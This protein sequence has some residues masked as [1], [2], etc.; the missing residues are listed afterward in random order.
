VVEYWFPY[1]GHPDG[2]SELAWFRVVDGTGYRAPGNPDGE[3]DEACFVI[4]EDFAFPTFSMPG[5]A[6]M[7]QIVGSFVYTPQGTAWFRIVRAI[8]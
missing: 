7:F 3:S 6:P 1:I 5:D 8:H 2:E 4:V